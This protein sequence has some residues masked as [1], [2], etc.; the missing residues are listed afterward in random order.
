M[1]A[2]ARSRR[3]RDRHQRFEPQRTEKSISA[4][5][6]PTLQQL[7]VN[8]QAGIR[9]IFGAG[10]HMP[11][12]SAILFDLDGT[13]TEP[14]LDFPR[15]HREMGIGDRGILEAMAEM[16]AP[17]RARAEAILLRHE[18]DAA[19]GSTLNTDC[20]EL[21]AYIGGRL[22]LAIVTRN[23][24]E[25]TR[26]VLAKHG[27]SFDVLITREYGIFKPGPEPVMEACRRLGVA[28]H[29]TWMVGDG[30]FDV[31]AGRAAG[32]RTVWVSHGKA[33]WFAAEPW[34]SVRD[35]HELTGMLKDCL[36]C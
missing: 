5:F 17:R 7:R 29:R 25:S 30:Q 33:K 19:E 21:L 1:N 3:T 13:L 18:K 36:Y 20:R 10:V 15:I 14:L 2:T 35:L 26:T 27:L 34:A 8:G 4:P 6:A 24:A 31:E 11:P 32:A 22:P 23:S 9:T 16:D 12:P 28:A